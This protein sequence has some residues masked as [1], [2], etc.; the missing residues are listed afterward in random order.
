VEESIDNSTLPRSSQR[1][2]ARRNAENLFSGRQQRTNMAKEDAASQSALIDAKT[3][4]L[5]A[6][7]LARDEAEAQ[8]AK[9]TPQ[10]S[11]SAAKDRKS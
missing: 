9:D 10:T 1:E 6:L 3:L 4:R 11:G 8:S 5:R 2:V 7:R